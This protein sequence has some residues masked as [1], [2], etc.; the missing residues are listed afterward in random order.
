MKEKLFSIIIILLL[1]VANVCAKE[2][3]LHGVVSDQDGRPIEFA[4]V[5][6]NGTSRGATTDALGKYSFSLETQNDSLL[7]IF[8]YIGYKNDS[9]KVSVPRNGDIELSRKLF[10]SAYNLENL[11][12]KEYRKQINDQQRIDVE[13]LKS[14]PDVSGNSI[15]ALVA[16]QAGVSS[17]NE[18]SSQYSVRGGNY[19]ENSVYVNGIEVY[20][21][22]LIRA[23]QQEGLSF[24]NPDLV[25][26]VSFSSGGFSAQYG[27]KMSSVLDITY[28]KPESFEG[29]FSVSLL[30]ASVYIGSANKKFT[31]IH[32]ARYKTSAYMLGSLETEGEYNPNFFDYQT[33]LTYSFTP[34]VE[35]SFLG[36]YSV[37]SYKFVP[38]S[39]ETSF[40][41]TTNMKK[42]TVYF[43][44]QEK[45]LFNTLFGAFSLYFKPYKNTKLGLVAS[46][47][48]TNEKETYDIA[49]EYRLGD[50]DGSNTITT[51]LGD[52]IGKY[53][54]HTRNR[55]NA[56]VSSLSQIGEVNL[57]S[58][59][60]KWGLTFQ[61][62]SIKDKTNEW[63]MRDSA[64]FSMPY[65]D[66]MLTLYYNLNSDYNVK[67]NRY[68][69]YLQDTYT[70]T[71]KDDKFNLT[72]GV[73]A[74]YWDFNEELLISP[75][76]SLSWIPSW[77]KSFV[78][79][80]ATGIYYQSPFFKEIRDT[81][82][83]SYGNTQIRLNH[84][85]KAQR[86]YQV[87]FGSDYYFRSWNRP[88]KFT[89]E[90]YYKYID[91]INPYSVDNVKIVYLGENCAKGY[92]MGIDMKLFGEFVP[93]TDSWINFSLM[94][95]KEDLYDDDQGFI[96][97]PTDQRYNISLFFQDYFPNYEKIKF[98]IKLIWADGLPFSPPHS[99]RKDYGFRTPDY[100]RIDIGAIYTLTKN[101]DKLMNYKILSWSKTLSLNLELFNLL[102]ISNVNSY[103]WVTD[104]SNV[105]Y[106]V[107]NYLTGRRLNVKL[108]V[109][110]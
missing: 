9:V 86:S 102:D 65:N 5:T 110:F 50:V 13:K 19:D 56:T 104:V 82:S 25:R 96:Y 14:V 78:F 29:A 16:T 62:E 30:G 79:R 103:Y 93:G 68:I 90:L 87:L 35:A 31:Q 23:G 108:Q 3:R 101:K 94:Q 27:D 6:V 22:M 75:R 15:E 20:R 52:G 38:E 28:K 98:N 46:S 47:F 99:R 12:V 106:A 85:I 8:S 74:N 53:M 89:T 91:R 32:G 37:N 64:G 34:K 21:P 24:V 48:N 84:D 41:T 18:L 43:D 7:I 71:A 36:N 2:F 57:E 95:T 42:F 83:D 63:E 73:R 59:K 72:G 80:L 77:K 69:A 60:I 107:P 88:F 61:H 58:N 40:G 26:E 11:E 70:W 97:R 45:D 81:L 44:G 55:L 92:A 49:G 17:N 1:C 33:Y 109:E 10:E 51:D 66:D 39:R 67:S 76:A 54:E 105:Q 100:R 4:N